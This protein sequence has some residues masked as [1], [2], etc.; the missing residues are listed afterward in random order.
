MFEPLTILPSQLTSTPNLTPE[1]RLLLAV[2]EDAVH[3][4]TTYRDSQSRIEQK[5]YQKAVEWF[6]SDEVFPFSFVYCCQV[7]KL[8]AA[9]I[10]KRLLS[11]ETTQRIFRAA[12]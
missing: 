6:A 7:L 2:F 3:V 1:K 11:T 10:R 8:E 9:W 5:L 12:V 4:V